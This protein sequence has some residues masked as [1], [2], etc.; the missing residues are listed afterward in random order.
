MADLEPLRRKALLDRQVVVRQEAAQ[1]VDREDA[2]RHVTKLDRAERDVGHLCDRGH[3][4]VSM[5]A[6]M[7]GLGGASEL[8][9]G[10]PHDALDERLGPHDL[11]D[12]A[13]V[14]QEDCEVEEREQLGHDDAQHRCVGGLYLAANEERVEDRS[15]R[16][17]EHE[18]IQRVAGEDA[19]D[20]WRVPG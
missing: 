6:R 19:D 15:Q 18:R 5:P 8:S 14:R 16:E 9:L 10:P 12:V 17:A 1:D 11:E 13:D 3:E 2:H 7:A 4:R 20:A